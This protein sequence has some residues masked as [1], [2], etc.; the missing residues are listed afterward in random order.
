MEAAIWLFNY[1]DILWKIFT[2]ESV[3]SAFV[4]S[5]HIPGS[6]RQMVLA[7]FLSSG[8][9]CGGVSGVQKPHKTSTE[10]RIEFDHIL[11]FSLGGSNTIRNVQILCSNC[12]SIK[13]A[14]AR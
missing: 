7:D 3:D 4:H 11:P 9:I 6:V 8:Q 1:L 5:R 12:N 10:D 2:I 14:T 13:R